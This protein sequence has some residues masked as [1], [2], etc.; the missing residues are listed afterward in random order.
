MPICKS[1]NSWYDAGQEE[2]SNCY[3]STTEW[4][5]EEQRSL[6]ERLGDY[7]LSVWGIA[8]LAV[9]GFPLL[10]LVVFLIG[11][12]AS[13]V[14]AFPPGTESFIVLSQALA[15]A[16][17]MTVVASVYTRRLALRDYELLRQVETVERPSIVRWAVILSSVLVILA[18][19]AA[20]LPFLLIETVRVSFTFLSFVSYPMFIVAFALFFMLLATTNFIGRLN[21][22]VPQPIYLRV[23]E[24]TALV[25]NSAK[26]RLDRDYVELISMARTKHGGIRLTIKR[27]EEVT[28]ENQK[29]ELVTLKVSK[30]WEVK[31]NRWGKLVSIEELATR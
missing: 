19:L 27:E 13:S 3:T 17:W 12:F 16:L 23:N 24:L 29:G 1:C 26:R 10:V 18:G 7:F 21:E 6:V 11:R 9:A 5:A 8:A 22:G 20:T 30:R 14:I 4:E 31:A 25:I 2:C 15:L 28:R